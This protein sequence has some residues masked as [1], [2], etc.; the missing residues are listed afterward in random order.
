MESSGIMHMP[1]HMSALSFL[2]SF[3][4]TNG[5][6][7]ASPC[8]L[9]T[10]RCTSRLPSVGSA[11]HANEG[12]AAVL[13]KRGSE[14]LVSHELRLFISTTKKFNMQIKK[15]LIIHHPKLTGLSLAQIPGNYHTWMGIGRARGPRGGRERWAPPKP[16]CF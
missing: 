9:G 8:C 10:S 14:K 6:P 11:E 7:M 2:P 4:T 1:T 12:L 15:N 3:P 13:W 5:F 16:I